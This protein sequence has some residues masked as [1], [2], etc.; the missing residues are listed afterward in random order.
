MTNLLYLYLGGNELTGGIPAVLGS[1]ANLWHLSLWG[2]ALDGEIPPELGNLTRLIILSLSNNTLTGGIPAELGDLTNLQVLYLWGNALDGEIPEELGDLTSLWRLY[3]NGNEL[4]GEIPA[5]LGDLT[6]LQRLYLY[7]NALDG[8]IPEE[9]GSLTNLQYLYL[10]SNELTGEIPAE[11]GSLTSLQWLYLYDNQLD[12]SIPTQ[13]GSLTSLQRLQL[14][15]NELSGTIPA[16][17]GSLTSLQWLLLYGNA[18]DGEIPEELGDLTSLQ[19][20]YLHSNELTGEIPAELGSLTSLQR[21]YLYDNQL[22]GSIPTQLGSLTSLQ[23]LQLQ[24]NELSGTIP[25]EL[26]DLTS[27]QRLYLYDNQLTGPIP[28]ELGSLTSLLYLSLWSNQLTGAI[29]AAVGVAADRGA[30]EG[31]YNAT[32]GPNWTVGTNW[33]TTEEPLSA[34]HGVTPDSNGRVTRVVL[35]NN[36]LTGT[37]SV[38]LEQ[39]EKLEQL[40]LSVNDELTG[41]LP[42]GLR[43]LSLTSLDVSGTNVCTPEDAAFLEWV[44]TI[45]FKPGGCG[46]VSPPRPP[47]GGGGGGGGG[48]PRTSVPSAVRNLMAAG[49]NGQVVLTWDAPSSDG[50]AEITDYEYRINGSGPWISTGSTET[51]HTVTGLDNGTPYVFEVRAVNRR[52]RGRVSNRNR[53]EATPDVFTLDFAHFANGEGLTSDL[54]FVNVGTHPIRPALAFYDQ[55][56]Q[57]MAPES[58][59]EITGDLEVTEDGALSIQTAIEPLGELTISTH[60]QGEL[61][62]GPA[63]VTSG[64]PIGGGLRFDLPE[65]GVAGVGVSPPVRDAVFP[66]RRQEGG[67]NTGVAIHNLESSPE[68][69]RCELM[70]E[71]VLRDAVSLPLAANGQSSWFIDAAFPAAD[72]TDFAGSVRCDAEGPGQFTAVALE[73]DAASRIFTTLPV[74]P[75][76]RAGGRAAELTFAHF[77]NGAGII[78]D[79]VFVNLSTEGSRPAPTPYHQDILPLRPTIYFYDTEGALVSAESVVDITGDLAIQEDGGLT[80]LTEMEPLGVLTISTHGRGELVSGSVR[81]AADEP[82]GGVLRFDL[83]GIGVAGVG[84]SPPVR[85]VLF[86]VRRQEGG[87]NT[88]VAV[89]NLGEEAMEVTCELMQGGTVLDDVSIPLAANGQSSWFIDEV[90]TGADTSD[91]AGS[92]RCAAP[93]EG[94]FTGVAVELD[95]VNR[96]FTTLP[97]V[98]VPERMSQE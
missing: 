86:P 65:I 48:T 95:A 35:S 82:I 73:L 54:V 68:I 17:L 87:I 18:L 13:L 31:F 42:D 49:G 39:L 2:N 52:G 63:R 6:N 16:A 62:S 88:G 55:E 26:G 33:L 75:V 14:Q 36:Q 59:V 81:V 57:P 78:S 46:T 60:G 84:T 15:G 61:V 12:G 72:T 80:V 47:G 56:G 27:L 96:I 92:V 23:R 77:A 85:D 7:G 74:L 4:S 20:L 43:H 76:R 70:R 44:A 53:A 11:L 5:K 71:G 32:D 30:L 19:F 50:G 41:Q 69:V 93:G 22:D 21:L 67:I 45:T 64:G 66:V 38:A 37:I 10:H 40:N 97:V 83:P 94:M 98:P 28:A 91:F 9:L 3:L 90:F 25:S 51:T 58:V 89:H 24:G 1:L 79:L 29:P 8:E 34:W